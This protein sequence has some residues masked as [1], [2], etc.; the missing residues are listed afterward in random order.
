M[1]YMSQERKKELAPAIKAALQKYGLKGSL[2][3]QHHSGLSLWIKSGTIDFFES[4][5]RLAAKHP[6]YNEQAFMPAKGNLQVNQY[7][8][9]EHFDGVAKDFLKE[10]LDAMNVGNHDNS[11]IQSDYFDVG[12]YTYVNIGSWDEPYVLE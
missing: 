12:W 3:V 6:R 8:Y 2:S 4:Y 9:H 1:A 11:D 7:W 10:V 5:N